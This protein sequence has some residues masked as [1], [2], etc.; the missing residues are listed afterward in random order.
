MTPQQSE[1]KYTWLKHRLHEPFGDKCVNWPGGLDADGYGNLRV[2]GK[3]EKV[4]HI[5]MR[6]RGRER[7]SPDYKLMH[8]CNN[9]R[10][11]NPK[12]LKW[13]TESQNS[14]QREARKAGRPGGNLVTSFKGGDRRVW[15]EDLASWIHS[16]T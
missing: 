14:T 2:E 5:V 11:I 15:V 16:I 4:S 8:K 9:R 7:P 1:D 13:G 3:V 10:C 12:H 6:L